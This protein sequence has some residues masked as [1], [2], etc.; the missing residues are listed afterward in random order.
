MGYVADGVV[1]K[2]NLMMIALSILLLLRAIYIGNILQ[3]KTE[4]NIF[5]K[6]AYILLIISGASILI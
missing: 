3:K 6:L 2:R 5:L 4:Q 1:N